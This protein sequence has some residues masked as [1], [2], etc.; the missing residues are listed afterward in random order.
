[1]RSHEKGSLSA[2]TQVK[3]LCPEIFLVA[4]GQG[5]H[6]LE[7]HWLPKEFKGGTNFQVIIVLT[8]SPD[9]Y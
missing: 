1:M 5:I 9:G 3:V 2:V 6:F 7:Y 8:G 4:L